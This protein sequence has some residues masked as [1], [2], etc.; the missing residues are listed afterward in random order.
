MVNIAPNPSDLT[1]QKKEVVFFQSINRSL[2]KVVKELQGFEFGTSPKPSHVFF[3]LVG[4]K[5]N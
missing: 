4:K 2:R 1:I 3:C 5:P